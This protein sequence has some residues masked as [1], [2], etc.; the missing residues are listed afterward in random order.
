MGNRAGAAAAWCRGGL[1]G[2]GSKR[3]RG[4]YRESGHLHQAGGDAGAVDLLESE[5]PD[6]DRQE[7]AAEGGQ[8]DARSARGGQPAGD[9]EPAAD[10][11]HR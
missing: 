1:R 4:Q 8:G 10:G 2:G 9:D 11:E 6:P 5:Q 7:V 3:E